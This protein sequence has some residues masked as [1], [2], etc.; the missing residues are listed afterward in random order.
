MLLWPLIPF[1]MQKEEEVWDLFFFIPDC[2]FTPVL[3]EW[4]DPEVRTLA[5]THTPIF[6]CMSPIPGHNVYVFLAP[7]VDLTPHLQKFPLNPHCWSLAP[8]QNHLSLAMKPTQIDS[9][10]VLSNDILILILIY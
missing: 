5:L 7:H 3:W 1:P 9:I 10:L 4:E 6:P 8:H 2:N